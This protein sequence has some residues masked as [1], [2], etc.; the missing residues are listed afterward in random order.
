M[1]KTKHNLRLKLSWDYPRGDNQYTQFM[2]KALVTSIQD[3]LKKYPN[4]HSRQYTHNNLLGKNDRWGTRIDLDFQL[5]T[6]YHGWEGNLNGNRG[7]SVNFGNLVKALHGLD[8]L[9]RTIPEECNPAGELS[10]LDYQD[11][12]VQ[13]ITESGSM[14]PSLVVREQVEIHSLG[15]FQTFSPDGIDTVKI[16]SI[17]VIGEPHES[18]KIYRG[19]QKAGECKKVDPSK[20][21]LEH[22]HWL[23][24]NRR[25]SN[26]AIVVTDEHGGIWVYGYAMKTRSLLGMNDFNHSQKPFEI[27]THKHQNR[28][29]FGEGL[30]LID[31]RTQNN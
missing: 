5:K 30:K 16:R 18:Y 1:A 3:I 20:A 22:V 24:E 4:I 14:V 11:P 10:T 6:D 12:W 31:L 2:N 25:N 27:I 13:A 9:L 26:W 28:R 19:L 23:Y 17:G 21:L 7:K 15:N 29:K 8:E